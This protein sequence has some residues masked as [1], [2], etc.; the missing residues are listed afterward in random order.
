MIFVKAFAVRRQ[1]IIMPRPT[2]KRVEW[3][4]G[5]VVYISDTLVITLG[6]RSPLPASPYCRH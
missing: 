6:T 4:E 5:L 1:R 2:R 3:Q